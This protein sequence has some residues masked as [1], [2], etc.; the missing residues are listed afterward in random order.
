[1]EI[2]FLSKWPYEIYTR[3]DFQIHMRIKRNIHPICAYSFRF[4]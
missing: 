1:M 2:S 3:N 4:E